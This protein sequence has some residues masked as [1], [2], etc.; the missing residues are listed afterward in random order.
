VEGKSPFIKVVT[1]SPAMA[2]REVALLHDIRSDA[3]GDI[4]EVGKAIHAAV[5][6]DP[7]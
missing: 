7:D 5:E 4:S 2:R 1:L 3:S 6:I